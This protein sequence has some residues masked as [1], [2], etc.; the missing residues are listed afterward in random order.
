LRQLNIGAYLIKMQ[1][2]Q[3]KIQALKIYTEMSAKLSG[4]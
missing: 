2:K 1:K 4:W 3:S